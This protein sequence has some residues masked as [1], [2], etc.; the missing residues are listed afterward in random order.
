MRPL[1]LL[2]HSVTII[3]G[4]RFDYKISKVHTPY[5]AKSR[6]G[7]RGWNWTSK[8]VLKLGRGSWRLAEEADKS[9]LEELMSAHKHDP[10]IVR[11]IRF[12]EELVVLLAVPVP[13]GLDALARIAFLIVAPL[14]GQFEWAIR[15]FPL[16]LRGS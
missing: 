16:L 12:K 6:L 8:N 5:L 14:I 13:N 7:T 15:S 11:R 4:A 1:Q 2:V 3:G 9:G 10:E